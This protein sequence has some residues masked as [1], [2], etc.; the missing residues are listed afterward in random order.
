MRLYTRTGDGGQT[1]L[2][3]GRRVPKNHPRVVAYGEVDELCAAVGLAVAALAP[4]RN[5]PEA[6]AR[7]GAAAQR[8]SAD[9]PAGGLPPLGE[10]LAVVQADLFVIGSEL[11]DPEGTHPVPPVGEREIERLEQWIDAAVAP[12]PPLR[13]FVLPG[14][15][16]AAARL[17]LARTICRRAERGLVALSANEPISA[18][19]ATYLNRLADLL[20]ALARLVNHRCGAGDVAW[21]PR[22]SQ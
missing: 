3:G 22:R 18:A 8:V 20:F 7:S 16:E 21:A 6:A 2:I 15:C 13:S 19:C 10:L 17:H 5:Q 4:V 12:V 1:G 14:G 9:D 11:A